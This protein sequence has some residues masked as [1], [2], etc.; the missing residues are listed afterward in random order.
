MGTVGRDLGKEIF[1]RKE[2][3]RVK[4][5]IFCK[6]STN[7]ERRTAL[8]RLLMETWI[9]VKRILLAVR[10]IEGE[11]V[12]LGVSRCRIMTYRTCGQRY[13]K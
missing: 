11:L 7:R 10:L 6:K 3:G 4:R 5:A 8:G 13:Q 9:T 12:C 2:V 1:Y